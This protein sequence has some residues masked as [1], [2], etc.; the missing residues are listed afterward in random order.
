MKKFAI[1]P[2]LAGCLLPLAS[3]RAIDLKQSKVTQVVND[4][5][6]ISA[7]DK[8]T[9]PATV[10]AIFKMPDILRTGPN[11]RAELVADDQTITRVGA[12]TVFAFDPAN[13]TIDLQKGSLLFH[14]PKGKGGGTIQTGSATASV[15]GTTIVV[16]TTPDGGFKLLVLE[17]EAE[18]KFLN[19]ILQRVKAGQMTFILPGGGMSPIIMF[20]LDNNTKGSRLVNGFGNALPSLSKIENEVTKQDKMIKQGKAEDT[21]LLVGN[22]A[23]ESQVEAL[24]QSI[25][26]DYFNQAGF[27]PA[28]TSK[29]YLTIDGFEVAPYNSSEPAID[30][31]APAQELSADVTINSSTLSS[32]NNNIF[33]TTGPFSVTVPDMDAENLFLQNP[34]SGFFGRNINIRTRNIDMTPY[35]SVPKFDFLAAQDINISG[36]LTFNGFVPSIYLTAGGQIAIASGSTVSANT[37]FLYLGSFDPMQFSNV[38]IRNTAGSIQL[39]SLSDLA[40]NNGSV[41]AGVGVQL[42]GHTGVNISGTHINATLDAAQIFSDATISLNNTTLGAGGNVVVFANG[43]VS[44]NNS[45][46]NSSGGRPKVLLSSFEGSLSL[47]GGSISLATVGTPAAGGA[48]AAGFPSAVQM[49]AAT[50]VNIAGTHITS[51]S[52]YV[53][54]GGSIAVN[55]GA[56]IAVGT[57]TLNAG[58]GILLDNVTMS[59]NTLNMIAKNNVNVGSAAHHVDLSSYSD[60]N[61]SA[62]TPV[63]QNVNFGGNVRITSNNGLLAANPNTG[64]AVQ[65]GYVNFITGVTYTHTLIT[66]ANQATFINP[67]SGSGIFLSAGAP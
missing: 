61:I 17:G 11:S 9:K 38:N 63:F 45:T 35:G 62:H 55:G 24:D 58:D 50:D 37:S 8:S 65:R 66:S 7:S 2:L 57:V 44:V 60:V 15:L 40:L 4:V 28:A 36:S 53:N 31:L 64:Q 13:R 23:T 48:I 34:F 20:R 32:H 56:S 1:Y 54:A 3:S 19:G 46:L 16:T 18:I 47:N 52:L 51:D 42:F 14:S 6:I 21:G 43:D 59:G 22:K 49:S 39:A 10:N 29:G 33:L 67:V 12:N 25:L 27:Q 30:A 5:Q 41:N 26:Q